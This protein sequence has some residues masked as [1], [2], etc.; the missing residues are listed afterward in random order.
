MI[1]E[2]KKFGDVN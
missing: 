1:I 2:Q